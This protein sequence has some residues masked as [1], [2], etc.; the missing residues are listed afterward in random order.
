ML[1]ELP[2]VETSKQPAITNN[3]DFY[4]MFKLTYFSPCETELKGSKGS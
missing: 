1:L 2:L 3:A 4:P